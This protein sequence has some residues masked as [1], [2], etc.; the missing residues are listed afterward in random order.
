MAAAG[1]MLSAFLFFDNAAMA[2]HPDWPRPTFFTVVAHPGDTLSGI[3][4]RY[5]VPAGVVT[6]LN[7][8]DPG[9]EVFA[10]EILRIPANS[11]ATRDTVFEEALDRDAR[12]YAP[13]AKSFDKKNGDRMRADGRIDDH[14]FNSTMAFTGAP[15]KWLGRSQKS[16]KSAGSPG[17]QW[18]VAGPVI[19]RFGTAGDGER[20]DG[21]N[22]AAKLGDP[23]RAAAA[24]IVTYA[25]NGLR[26]HGNLILIEHADGYVTAY[27]HAESIV[28]ARGEQVAKGQVIGAAG[29]SGSVDQPQLH[30][31]I[32][33][34]VKPVNPRLLLASNP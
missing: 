33:R 21:I 5:G 17:F 32:R 30:F 8:L 14:D 4:A 27:A 2:R 19:S 3:A 26:D 28:V 1:A 9:S 15:R 13:P 11:S 23:I 24:G 6:R 20:N 22:I 18:P 25:D 10:G 12:N 16:P 29:D 7:A 34:G 31:E